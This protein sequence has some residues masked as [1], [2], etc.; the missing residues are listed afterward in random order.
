[1]LDGFENIQSDGASS[2]SIS[3]LTAVFL[4]G[5]L[6]FFAGVLSLPASASPSSPA[7][8]FFGV[9]AADLVS[10]ARSQY[11]YDPLSS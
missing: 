9:E 8:R 10:N 7:A 3:F 6:R 11:V 5:D 2:G 4:A 1:M